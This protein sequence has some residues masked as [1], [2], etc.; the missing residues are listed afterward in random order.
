MFNGLCLADPVRE[1]ATE[2][3]EPP[4]TDGGVHPFPRE[5]HP[6]RV[7]DSGRTRSRNPTVRQH[8]L[9]VF[10]HAG[11]A[12]PPDPKLIQSLF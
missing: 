3:G 11:R 12:T 4:G 9:D 8:H 7:V 5:G 10:L 6:E 1:G 2:L